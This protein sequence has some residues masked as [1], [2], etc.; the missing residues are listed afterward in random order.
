VTIGRLLMLIELIPDTISIGDE[1]GRVAKKNDENINNLQ[2][3]V[4]G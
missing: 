4:V 3:Y 2:T 1:G